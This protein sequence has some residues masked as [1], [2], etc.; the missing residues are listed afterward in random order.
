[1]QCGHVVD[2]SVL[3]AAHGHA[4]SVV[5]VSQTEVALAGYA[6][7]SVCQWAQWAIPSSYPQASI[8]N[9]L[10]CRTAKAETYFFQ[11]LTRLFFYTKFSNLSLVPFFVRNLPYTFFPKMY[12]F[13]LG[14]AQG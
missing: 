14:M 6:L 9:A 8:S 4:F 3:H 1:M 12:M 7:G 5:G 13:G 11:S 10:R 2:V